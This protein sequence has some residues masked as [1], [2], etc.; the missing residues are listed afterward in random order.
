MCSILMIFY[1]YA[2]F[3]LIQT[4]TQ[5]DIFEKQLKIINREMARTKKFKHYSEWLTF[6]LK[7]PIEDNSLVVKE[8]DSCLHKEKER[9][10]D[11]NDLYQTILRL[12][13]AIKDYNYQLVERAVIS[14][15]LS[16]ILYY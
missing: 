15:I 5:N 7:M 16:E 14:R 3:L 8:L 9:F 1:L 10:A 2:Y 6:K 4:S 12:V 11:L 13:Q